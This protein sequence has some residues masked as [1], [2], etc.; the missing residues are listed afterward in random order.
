MSYGA[1]KF[2]DAKRIL[3]E[4]RKG[5]LHAAL[6]LE[7]LGAQGAADRYKRLAGEIQHFPSSHNDN[8]AGCGSP[9][10]TARIRNEAITR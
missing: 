9:A 4:A 5:L 3:T 2:S 10:D 8:C 7:E 1:Q 6:L